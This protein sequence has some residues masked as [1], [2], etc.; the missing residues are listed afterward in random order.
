MKS[1]LRQLLRAIQP[2]ILCAVSTYALAQNANPGTP[3]ACESTPQYTGY[4]EGN[5]TSKQAGALKVSLNLA[6][7]DNHYSGELSTPVGKFAITKGA[8]Q[9]NHLELTI[10]AEGNDTGTIQAD[11]S[12]TK[13]TGRFVLGDDSGPVDLL[14]VSD[15]KTPGSDLPT[16]ALTPA[17]W[18]E[19]LRYFAAEVPKQHANA[20]YHLSKTEFDSMVANANAE[21]EHANGDESYVL[22]DRI[23]N[24]IGD[25][26]TFIIWPDDLSHVPLQL[27]LFN[28]DYR[29]TAVLAG[30]ERALGAR[31]VKVGDMPIAQV[32]EKLRPLTPAAETKE[33]G[34]IR[35]EDF[36]LIGML[37]HGSDIIPDRKSITYTLAGEDGHEFALTLTGM[38]MHEFTSQKWITVFKQRPLYMQSRN[39]D[40]WCEF[41]ASSQ[42][43]YCNF[44]GYD[45]LQQNASQMMTMINEH[46]PRQVAI[47]FRSN[48][49]GDYTQGEKYVI[50][51]LR[52]MPDIN[53]HGHLFV[54]TSPYTFSAGMSN[55]AQF[56]TLTHAILVGQPIGER[57]NSYQEARELRLP[58]SHLVVRVS[59]HHYEFAPGDKD[60][61][62]RP[63]KEID[64][65]WNDYRAGRDAVLDW[66]QQGEATGK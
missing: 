49:G 18:H 17:Q 61:V 5:V 47:D 28:G 26:H 36:L 42:T 2:A 40:L 59:T 35:M 15:A 30:N 41:L 23:A 44:I 8:L 43:M 19:D 13:L 21:L 6:C 51:P 31:V 29:V 25:G 64:R 58:N 66:V 27:R 34:D 3:A 55:A 60:N 46:H 62:V 16:L 1:K 48:L 7:V 14:R 11:L 12:G 39:S 45:N 24:A 63:D 53:S 56:R 33:L 20:F 38:P 9:E 4:F 50:Q 22:I 52:A 37:L 10:A 32:L 65:N 57:P 54:L